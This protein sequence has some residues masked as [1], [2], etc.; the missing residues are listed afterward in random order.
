[1]TLIGRNRPAVPRREVVG[2]DVG[3]GDGVEGERGA[4]R[5]CEGTGVH[6]QT[7]LGES[8]KGEWLQDEE[9]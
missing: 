6:L 8:L 5:P 2:R 4:A 1:M 7:S 3:E 9:F